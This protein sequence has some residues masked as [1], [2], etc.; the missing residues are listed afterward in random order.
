M[1]A[2]QVPTWWVWISGALAILGVQ[3]ALLALFGQPWYCACGYIK[4]WEGVVLSV[5]NSQHI[6]DWYTYSHIIHGFLFYALFWRLFPHAPVWVRFLLAL[7]LESSWEVLENTPWVIN[8]YRE[9]ALAAGY[10]GDS[11]LNSFSDSVAMLVGFVLAWRLPVWVIVATALILEAMVGYTI[12][13]N[14]TLNI[15]NLLYP[16]DVVSTWQMQ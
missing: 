2:I 7:G 4:V 15:V 6:T 11:I 16:S 3:V 9:Q 14:L 1:T 10:V 5:G 13:D 12:R 8:H